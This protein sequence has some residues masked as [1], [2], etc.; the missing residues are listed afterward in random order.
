MSCRWI[1]PRRC[2]ASAAALQARETPGH[3]TQGCLYQHG[4]LQPGCAAAAAKQ[5]GACTPRRGSGHTAH[6]TRQHSGP[7]QHST[8]GEA[9]GSPEELRFLPRLLVQPRSQA[10]QVAGAG[11]QRDQLLQLVACG[12]AGAGGGDGRGMATGTM[13]LASRPA[14]PTVPEC[15]HACPSSRP[16]CDTAHRTS[17]AP[18]PYR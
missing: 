8:G 16:V 15:T 11:A 14:Q 10:V 17:H 6:A 3:R 2:S 5:L 1:S 7:A 9:A 18:A 13:A 4:R 12:G